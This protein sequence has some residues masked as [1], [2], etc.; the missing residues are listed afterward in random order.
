[1]KE[2]QK[3]D[4]IY[5]KLEKGLPLTETE[6]LIHRKE[7]ALFQLCENVWS[8]P[9]E[10]IA[11]NLSKKVRMKILKERT[12]PKYF[13]ERLFGV[14]LLF[15]FIGIV[16]YLLTMIAIGDLLYLKIFGFSMVI[17]AI[18]ILSEYRINKSRIINKK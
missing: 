14:F 1:M 2:N 4:S 18:Y 16:I 7:I 17:I 9:E 5:Y 8:E 10:P 12:T 13:I 6:K 15:S 3:E 11:S